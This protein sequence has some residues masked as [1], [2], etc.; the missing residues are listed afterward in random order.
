MR[1]RRF[2]GGSGFFSFFTTKPKT[3]PIKIT[4]VESVFSDI[5]A[6][7]KKNMGIDKT[8]DPA[9]ILEQVKQGFDTAIKKEETPKAQAETPKAQAETPTAQAAAQASAQTADQ[10]AAAA[11]VAAQVNPVKTTNGS[12]TRQN[13]VPAGGGKRKLKRRKTKRRM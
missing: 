8:V 3:S 6:D 12:G 5:I 10:G 13:A 9:V 4:E 1:T 2:R 7:A 11:P